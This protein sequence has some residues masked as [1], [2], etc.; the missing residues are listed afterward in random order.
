[1]RLRHD[2]GPNFV[3]SYRTIRYDL[4]A[5]KCSQLF[6]TFLKDM[7]AGV[8]EFDLPLAVTRRRIENIASY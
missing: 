7:I 4:I 1:M 3:E 8:A 2:N 5:Q 6:M